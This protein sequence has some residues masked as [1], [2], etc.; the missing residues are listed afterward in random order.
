MLTFKDWIAVETDDPRP[1]MDIFPSSRTAP[2]KNRHIVAVPDHIDAIHILKN[3]GHKVVSPIQRGYTWPRKPQWDVGWWMAETAEFLTLNKRAYVFSAMRTRKTLTSLWALDFLQ[4]QGAVKKALIVA[5]LSAMELAWADTIF[6][7]FHHRSFSVLYGSAQ[8]RRD[9]L[10]QDKD[11]Y[12]IN[13]DGVSVIL[14]ELVNKTDINCIICDESHE[15]KGG[16]QS[17]RGK[18][19][20]LHH[21]INKT[22]RIEWVWGLTG[23]PTPQSPT[24]AYWQSKL[25]TPDTYVGSFKRF[26]YETMF[27]VGPFRWVPRKGSEEQVKT[28]LTPSIRFGRE[29]V[30]QMEPCLI[31]RHA[32]LSSEQMQHYKTLKKKAM[33]EIAGKTVT[34]VNAAILLQ[35]LIMTAC[36]VLYDRDGNFL[37]IDFGPRLAVLEELIEQNEEKVLVFVPFTGALEAVAQ[38]L[39]KRWTVAVVDGR[40]STGARDKIFRSF[41]QEK[42]PFVIVAHPGTMAYSLELTAASLIIWYAPPAGGNKTYQ[43]ACARIDGGGQKAKID[44]AHISGTQEER[45]AYEVV[46]GRGRWQDVLLNMR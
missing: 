25:I 19:R 46:Q 44:I 1:L 29:V 16:P 18:W 37:Q 43:Q 6:T 36:G 32:E 23:T 21:L 41:Q 34:A 13:H 15:M 39:R 5:P 27:Q 38:K 9:L 3:L 45:R 42:D 35:K 11:I 31:E 26:K 20:S 24:D 40:V 17:R 14:E 28:L 12:I 10:A 2:Y 30:T 33:T 8:R 7:C 4:R 22:G